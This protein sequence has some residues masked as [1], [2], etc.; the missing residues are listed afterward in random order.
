VIPVPKRSSR[1]QRNKSQ[2]SS[3]TADAPP[4]LHLAPDPYDSNP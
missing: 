3:S 1:Q 2:G 4:P